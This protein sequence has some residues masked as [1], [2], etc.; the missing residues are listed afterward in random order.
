METDFKTY[1]DYE[2]LTDIQ[3]VRNLLKLPTEF[4]MKWYYLVDNQ[5][6]EIET[7]QHEDR[8]GS[9]QAKIDAHFEFFKRC[10][11]L[12]EQVLAFRMG[13]IFGM[14]DLS[15]YEKELQSESA[16][17]NNVNNIINKDLWSL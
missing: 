2:I 14:P 12:I 16:I 3:I 11:G 6:L 4:L 1:K 17:M 15:K 10:R 13:E 7:K 8:S 9:E 5:I